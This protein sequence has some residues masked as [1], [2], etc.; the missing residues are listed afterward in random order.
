MTNRGVGSACAVLALLLAGCAAPVRRRDAAVFF[1][2][3]P[4][5]PR[6]QY[7]VS[8]SGL[9]DIEKQSAFSRFVVGEQQNVKVDKPYGVGIRDGKVYV[10]DTNNTVAVF[11]LKS[12]TFGALKGASGPGRL[13]QPTNIAIDGD[14]TLFV[15]DPV[16]GQVVAFDRNDEY[17]RAYGEPGAW[18]PVDAAS[19]GDRLYVA[20][21]QNGLVKVFDRKSGEMVETLGDKG[22][23]SERLDRPTNL[24][25]DQE[26]D[27]FVTDVGRFQVVKFDRDGH[28]K[29]TFGKAGDNLGHFARPKGIAVDREG[30]LYAVDASFNNVQI[31]NP[32]GRLLMFF[33]GGGEQPGN[34]TLPAKVTI[35]Y[36]NVRYFQEYV[37]P[38]FDVEYLVLVT[39]QFGDRLVNVLA[40]GKERG[41]NYPSDADLLKE[42][43]EQRAR[44]MEKARQQEPRSPDGKAPSPPPQP[45]SPAPVP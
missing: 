24:A 14:G 10:C 7:L 9:K 36:D 8:Y 35:D 3:P 5:L 33:G 44:E 34:F 32:D 1:P 26:G 40:F 21:V 22:A 30:R 31:F 11:D 28:F 23:P 15:A 17:L 43:E 39:S 37:E 42:I 18:R 20:D 4:S 12:Q 45:P 27:L 6:I 41:R 38:G 19:F 13:V 25:F 2:P 29:A 16:R